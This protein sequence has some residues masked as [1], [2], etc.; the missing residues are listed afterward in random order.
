MKTQF[1]DCFQRKYEWLLI[2][3]SGWEPQVADTAH[4]GFFESWYMYWWRDLEERLASLSFCIWGLSFKTNLFNCESDPLSLH[5]QA[6]EPSSSCSMHGGTR[7]QLPFSYFWDVAGKPGLQSQSLQLCQPPA[8][9]LQE[10]KFLPLALD[11]PTTSLRKSQSCR[12]PPGHW[13]KFNL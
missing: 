7:R 1:R 5:R 11:T 2:A 10:D 13:R 12:V 6:L 8:Y 4:D 9:T 3:T